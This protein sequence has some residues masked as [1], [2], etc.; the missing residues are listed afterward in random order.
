MDIR[1]LIFGIGAQVA[2]NVET[3]NPTVDR[4]VRAAARI[5]QHA[6]KWAAV[7]SSGIR[8]ALHLRGE[9][10]DV[11]PCG[12]A[13]IAACVVCRQAT[14]FEHAM[15]SPADGNVVCFGCIA[16]AQHSRRSGQ[17]ISEE[18]AEPDE[19]CICR[20]PS[21]LDPR[22][23]VHGPSARQQRHEDRTKLRAK[24]LR[25]L[26]LSAGASW[27]EIRGQYRRK[28]AQNH[29]DRFPNAQ[30]KRQEDK[31]KKLNEAFEWLKRDEQRQAA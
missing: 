2:G 22:C 26:G 4:Y 12:G 11:Q 17:P 18:P 20:D 13:A 28:V 27:A 10:G 25:R 7:S 30:K 14:C 16:A 3:N 15:I 1:D 5:M 31:L 8:C 9:L 19:Q 23:P 24:Y 21:Q 29:P 6:G